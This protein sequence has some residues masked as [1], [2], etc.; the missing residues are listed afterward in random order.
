[1]AELA[2]QID[3]L[4]L[5]KKQRVITAAEY[6]SKVREA[7]EMQ[8]RLDAARLRRNQQARG[9]RAFKAETGRLA[10]I[11]PDVVEGKKPAVKRKEGEVAIRFTVYYKPAEGETARARK[12]RTKR[13]Q[14][15]ARINFGGSVYYRQRDSI[16]TT[17]KASAAQ[18]PGLYSVLP[19]A[20]GYKV[21][22]PQVLQRLSASSDE[23][24]FWLNPLSPELGFVEIFSASPV[25]NAAPFVRGAVANRDSASHIAITHH[26]FKCETTASGDAATWLKRPELEGGCGVEIL[27]S[28]FKDPIARCIKR[29]EMIAKE[30]INVA[31]IL[32]LC[33]G[34]EDESDLSLTLPQFKRFFEH[35]RLQLTVYD[36]KHRVLDE[37]SHRP[38]KV[39]SKINPKHTFVLHHNQHLYLLDNAA[40]LK[41]IQSIHLTEELEAVQKAATITVGDTYRI[42]KQKEDGYLWLDDINE[43]F[44]IKMSECAAV[45]VSEGAKTLRIFCVC[46]LD[47]L[48][49]QL[50]RVAGYEPSIS[51]QFGSISGVKLNVDGV[52]VFIRRPCDTPREPQALIENDVE[53]KLYT[54]WKTRMYAS[55]INE[56]N[57]SV[58]SHNLKKVLNE[59]GS[60]PLVGSLTAFPNPARWV[61][62]DFGKAYTSNV[63]EETHWIVASIFDE[64]VPYS[65][66][67]LEDYNLYVVNVKKN[68][69]VEMR[70]V[71][72]FDGEWCLK[73]GFEL[74][75]YAAVSPSIVSHIK[76]VLVPHRLVENSAAA[77]VKGLWASSLPEKHKKDIVNHIVGSCGKKYN[78]RQEVLVYQDRAEAL[79]MVEDSKSKVVPI[80]INGLPLHLLVNAAK[81][82]LRNGF[83]LIQEQV[84]ARMRL[85]LW[86]LA[87]GRDIKAVKTDCLWFDKPLTFVPTEKPSGVES[88]GTVW[89]NDV[90]TAPTAELRYRN[91]PESIESWLFPYEEKNTHVVLK[92]EWINDE[93]AAIFTKKNAIFVSGCAPG[94]GKSYAVEQFIKG[95][96]LGRAACFAPTNVIVA[97]L[98]DTTGVLCETVCKLL[99]IVPGQDNKR[100]IDLENISYVFVDEL[101]LC[102][103][104]EL[105]MLKLLMEK[106]PFVRWI[107]AGDVFQNTPAG[108]YKDFN[109]DAREYHLMCHRKMFG[110]WIDLQVPKRYK[111]AEQN[112]RVLQ[113]GAELKACMNGFQTVAWCHKWFKRIDTV[114]AVKGTV[115]ALRDRVADA[116]DTYL[117]NKLK[118]AGEDYYV[119]MKLLSRATLR[120]GGVRLANGERYNVESVGEVFQLRDSLQEVFQVPVA[121]IKKH[122]R[123]N[124]AYTGYSLQG[125][126]IDSEWKDGGAITIFDYNHYHTNKEWLWTAVSRLR[127]LDDVYFFDG[128][129]VGLLS[130]CEVKRKIVARL[131]L[132]RR[133]DIAAGRSL[134]GFIDVAYVQGLLEKIS[135]CACGA[136]LLDEWSIDRINNDLA[137]VV[138][139]VRLGCLSCNHSGAHK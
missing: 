72:L 110:T 15:G 134:D 9:R 53:F 139:N 132:H 22:R 95:L 74:I 38:A 75:A 112:A 6:A 20:T 69:W 78:E 59:C 50:V 86:L 64:F 45:Q 121:L 107:G 119:G 105:G 98:R 131:D 49:S 100:G 31:R 73:F 24:R 14:A 96:P 82:Q 41:N 76:A 46:D 101:A 23:F 29:K 70:D 10:A 120:V 79:A 92:N 118:P 123:Y 39:H 16:I 97:K 71:L 66:S 62:A 7:E 129:L 89:F 67:G 108:E 51:L 128:E 88:I 34:N 2:T 47:M 35:H 48:V 124:H 60:R 55:L 114:E 135:R 17:V 18:K 56:N 1:M 127:N 37:Y 85:K 63:M 136:D 84:Y 87:E 28:L 54:E 81:E 61:A 8:A 19:G 33:K 102:T 109:V 11:E 4:K 42:Q 25:E 68:D 40:S 122:F 116:L 80:V 117:H 30:T 137:H 91:A 113:M 130:D 43:L 104:K 12:E 103:V 90:S 57:K 126:T 138:G 5:L 133:A 32:M 26:H 115:I 99:G 3:Y 65:G 36:M 13:Q 83:R 44:A 111:N 125:F 58:Y 21:M 27:L 106:Y 93:Y 52:Q 77:V 94:A